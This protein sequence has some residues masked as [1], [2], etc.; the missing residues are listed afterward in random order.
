MSMADGQQEVRKKGGR[1]WLVVRWSVPTQGVVG[2]FLC[3][4]KQP[5]AQVAALGGKRDILAQL[6]LALEGRRLRG[7]KQHFMFWCAVCCSA[8]SANLKLKVTL[9]SSVLWIWVNTGIVSSFR[10]ALVVT[11]TSW[12]FVWEAAFCCKPILCRRDIE[13][14]LE[15]AGMRV[16]QNSCHMGSATT[17]SVR[18]P[19][20][21]PWQLYFLFKGEET[22]CEFVEAGKAQW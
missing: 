5:G 20:S 9:D 4:Q 18:M 6:S 2:L 17:A 1:E 22:A 11:L 15:A 3:W 13:S 19:T 16:T 21:I 7:S 12:G 8:T 14:G 10:R